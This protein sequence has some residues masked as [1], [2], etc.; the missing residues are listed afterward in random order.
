VFRQS[1]VTRALKAVR[2]AGYDVIK[3]LIGPDGQLEVTTKP[4]VPDSGE[5]DGTVIETPGQLRKL[6]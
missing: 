2:A 1:D 5:P 4:P 6:L 3:L